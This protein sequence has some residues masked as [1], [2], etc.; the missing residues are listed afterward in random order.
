MKTRTKQTLAI[1][2]AIAFMG[3]WMIASML[4]HGLSARDQP[5]ALEAALA[6]C[7]R[8]LAMPR[9]ARTAKN[10]VPLSNEVWSEGRAHFADHCALCHGNDGAGRTRIGQNLYPKAPDMR[11]GKTQSLSDGEIF[12]VIKNG[13]RLTGMPA[14]GAD[15]REG[16]R[17]TWLLVHFIRHLPKITQEEIEQMNGLNPRSPRESAEEDEEMRFLEGKDVPAPTQEHHH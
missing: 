3:V 6:R 14:W 11:S 7:I 8:L 10:P 2:T 16:D 15:A 5:T 9:S 1:V 4:R 12:Y 17:E 13:I